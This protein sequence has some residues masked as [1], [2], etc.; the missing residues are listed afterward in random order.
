MDGFVYTGPGECCTLVRVS[1]GQIARSV[2]QLR[3]STALPQQGSVLSALLWFSSLC[4]QQLQALLF[5]IHILPT[6]MFVTVNDQNNH[7]AVTPLTV[8]SHLISYLCRKR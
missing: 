7:D 4:I 1:L 6:V 2:T 3:Q 5:G 8:W